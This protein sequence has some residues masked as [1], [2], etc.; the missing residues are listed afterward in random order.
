MAFLNLVLGFEFVLNRLIFFQTDSNF[1]NC[2]YFY[3]LSKRGI[4]LFFG[5]VVKKKEGL[6]LLGSLKKN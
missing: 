3:Q 5:G 2:F 4:F 6:G 1:L